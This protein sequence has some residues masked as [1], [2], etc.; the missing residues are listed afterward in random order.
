VSIGHALISESLY[1]GLE[2]VIAEY[3]KK[4]T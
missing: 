1:Y 2:K 4:L 3:L